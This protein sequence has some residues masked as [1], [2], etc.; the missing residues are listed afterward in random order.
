VSYITHAHLAERPG[1]KELAEAATPAHL[2]ATP[3]ELMEAALTGA[4]RSSWTADENAR[5]DEALARIDDAVKDAAAV[6]DGFLAKRGYLPLDPVPDM[7][8]VWCRA[9]TRYNLHQHRVSNEGTDPIVRD[10][11][12][13][14]KLLQLTAD[15]KFSLGGNDPV[16]ASPSAVDVRFDASPSV[17]SRNELKAFR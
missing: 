8:T 1:A 9:I 2:R 5:A 13:A 15:G 3:P 16:Q 7:V 12:D 10:Y 11:R 17:F 14:M 4:D 6:I